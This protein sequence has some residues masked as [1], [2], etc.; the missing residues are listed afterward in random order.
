M[1]VMIHSSTEQMM[2]YPNA[3]ALC[4]RRIGLGDGHEWMKGAGTVGHLVDC[5]ECLLVL[6]LSD[7]QQTKRV[8]NDLLQRTEHYV[9]D[10]S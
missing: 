6:N 8:V 3:R 9:G 7:E 10:V 4:G 1:K 2:E 5:P